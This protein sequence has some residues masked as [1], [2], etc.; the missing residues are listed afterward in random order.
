[1]KLLKNLTLCF[2]LLISQFSLSA[3]SIWGGSV[4]NFN[5]STTSLSNPIVPERSNPEMSL[6][7]TS[8][9]DEMNF[10]SLGFGGQITIEMSQAIRN[11]EGYD[12]KV[13][14][15]T[16]APTNCTIYPERA[17]VFASQDG[18]NFITLGQTCQDGEFDLGTLNWARY[19]RIIDESPIFGFRR[20]G[21]V[22]AF[23]VDAI[24]GYYP[25]TEMV[26]T[27]LQ[28]GFATSVIDYTPGLRK[29]GTPIT[30]AR[31]NPQMAL[32]VPQGTDVINF[33]SLGF[34]GTLILGFDFV[35]FNQPGWDL[36][37]I[38][39]SFGNPTCQNYPEKVLVEVSKDLISWE[40]VD[41]ICLDGYVDVQSTDWFQ[42]IRLADRSAASQFS[43]SADGYDVD[44]VLTIQDCPFVQSRKV[45]D[46]DDVLTPD[47][48]VED[49]LFPNPFDH[50][51]NLNISEEVE[52]SIM[53][54]A[55][56]R[57]KTLK[58]TGKFEVDLKPGYYY[59][60]VRQKNGTTSMHK[61]VKR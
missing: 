46:Y 27:S 42:Y 50:T 18:C 26:P 51:I 22:D 57:I 3:Q 58:A 4:V 2:S 37:F 16:F 43:G 9:S 23:D 56:R 25:E 61:L 38:E 45:V 31:T 13:W 33:V 53:D 41:A 10:V 12:L 29:N 49:V 20:H 24:E 19:I 8:E 1:M 55:G 40:F 34:S 15:T 30:P 11:G 48:E 32:G 60:E 28:S 35:K 39:T 44:G 36:Q 6:G 17:R 52:V 21:E 59:F 5:Q 14:E 7:S 54:Y 47:E